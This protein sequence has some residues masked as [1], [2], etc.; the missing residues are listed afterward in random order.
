M[1]GLDDDIVRD[2]TKK[3]RT[4]GYMKSVERSFRGQST[5]LGRSIVL[6]VLC[7]LATQSVLAN[8]HFGFYSI[9][10]LNLTLCSYPK[11][12]ST[13][14][15]N[16]VHR[17]VNL[18]EEHDGHIKECD[19][20]W[21]NIFGTSPSVIQKRGV[22]L[23]YSDKTT[24]IVIIRDP[25]TRAVSEFGDQKRRKHVSKNATFIEFLNW[26]KNER[27]HNR[28]HGHISTASTMC[29]G[30]P[31]ARFD[32]VIELTDITS[33]NAVSRAVPAYGKLLED[34]WENCT[35]GFP[36]LYMAGSV[37]EHKNHDTD[38]PYRLCNKENLKHVC[39]IYA[40]DY[41]LFRER[42][43]VTM[44]CE[45]KTKHHLPHSHPEQNVIRL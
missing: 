40:D 42:F 30:L 41:T 5:A 18:F 28:I 35:N 33:F 24:N 19:A 8:Q 45:C 16:V 22:E 23:D 13:M 38:E 29:P 36:N 25:W 7:C 11:A 1:T 3:S 17:A 2:C 14:N 43:N 31:G 10:A 39:N 4:S 9:P 15:L 44:H 12:G 32:Y 37:A 21:D 34:G 27:D 26:A 20:T 6:L